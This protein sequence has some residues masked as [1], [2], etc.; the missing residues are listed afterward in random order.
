MCCMP[1][2]L[3]FLKQVNVE[4]SKNRQKQ[5]KSKEKFSYRLRDWNSSMKSS[6]KIY[7]VW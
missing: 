7:N 2:L 5:L 4:K 1:T 3:V 6:A